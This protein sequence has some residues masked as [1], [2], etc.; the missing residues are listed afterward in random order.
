MNYSSSAN[1]KWPSLK[2]NIAK[3]TLVGILK[4][5]PGQRAMSRLQE[6]A[7]KFFGSLKDKII[8][9]EVLTVLL[10]TNTPFVIS[11]TT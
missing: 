4:Q 6:N 2:E 3:D 9:E 11:I 8:E 7:V 5:H 1:K 10:S